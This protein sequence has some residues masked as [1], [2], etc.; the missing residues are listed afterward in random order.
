MIKLNYVGEKKTLENNWGS[1]DHAVQEQ[2]DL[3]WRYDQ[4]VL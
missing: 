2:N 1:L 4:D 3:I